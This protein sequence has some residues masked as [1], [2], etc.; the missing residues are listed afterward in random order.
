VILFVYYAF[1]YYA[2]YRDR[3]LRTSQ[4]ETRLTVAQLQ[5]LKMQLNPHFLFNTLHSIS[6]LMYT[7]VRAA[8]AMITRLGDFLRMALENESVQEVPLRQEL[9]FLG[10]YLD[11][12]KIRLDERL[13][14]RVD[15]DERALDARVPNLG[16][17][18][19]IENAIHHGI[20]HLPRG[21]AIELSAHRDGEILRI[22]VRNDRPETAGT[23]REGIGLTNVRARLAQLYGAA[24]RFHIDE[25]V[26][27]SV[28]VHLAIPF[29]ESLA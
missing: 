8:D 16:L 20:A 14:L 1:D 9:D 29:R 2:K 22:H 18:P 7:D 13:T 23:S 12:E 15:I 28:A 3:E 6:S 11:I 10:R 17:Q 27:G 4:L 25:S 19:L 26:D 24:H 21:G 5:A